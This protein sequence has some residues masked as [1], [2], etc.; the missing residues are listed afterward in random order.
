[1]GYFTKLFTSQVVK[2]IHV[3]NF[4]PELVTE[5]MN[6]ELVAPFSASEVKEV[7]FAMNPNKSP[8][9]DGMNPGFYET[10][11]D[12]VGP[13]VTEAYTQWLQDGI[14]P[15]ELNDTLIVLIPKKKLPRKIEEY[16][17]ISLCKVLYKIISKMLA[18]RLKKFL[19]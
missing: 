1:M 11:W 3:V 14:L 5:T 7:I 9:P 19:N 16:R 10:Y 13:F 12:I 17:P 4:I 15:S 2:W 8:G 6:E 18:N